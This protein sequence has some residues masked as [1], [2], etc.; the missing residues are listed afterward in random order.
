MSFKTWAARIFAGKIHRHTCWW[1]ER[2]KE[3]QDAT[4]LQLISKAKDTEFG[5]T[6]RFDQ[7]RSYEDFKKHVPVRDY[8]GLKEWFDKVADGKENVLWP[9]K[10]LYLAKTSGTTSGVKY[11]PITKDSISNHIHG[12]RNALLAYIHETGKADFVDGKL[13]FLSGSPE[14]SLKSGI[15]TGRLSGISNHH[16]PA[17]LKR[18]QLPSYQTNC[19]EDWETKVD[20]IVEETWNQDMRLISGI[21]PWVQMYFDRLKDKTGKKVAELFPNLSLFVY[22]GVNFE[23]Y[24]NKLE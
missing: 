14:L 1:S 13:I 24:R 22:G 5:R 12:A 17:Y 9:G 2:P 8:E 20:A 23:P 3:I 10:P 21:P 6:H 19:I 15:L 11:I 18:N 4:F 16:V 7:I